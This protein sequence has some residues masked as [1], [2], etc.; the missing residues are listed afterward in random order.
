MK[1]ILKGGHKTQWMV[2]GHFR[3]GGVPHDLSPS[4][5][6]EAEKHNIIENYIKDGKQISHVDYKKPFKAKKYTEKE[7]Y[8]WNKDKQV[9]ELT[10]LGIKPGSKEE[11]RVNQL[12]EAQK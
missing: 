2:S 7:F 12:L 11:E 3:D 6:T 9:Q 1:I 10:K 8:S 4:E 5:I